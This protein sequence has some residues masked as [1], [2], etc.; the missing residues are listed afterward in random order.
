MSQ[1][2]RYKTKTDTIYDKG[3]AKE[4]GAV[5]VFYFPEYKFI[6]YVMT[7]EYKG[8]EWFTRAGVS[9]YLVDQ[10]EYNIAQWLIKKR[11]EGLNRLLNDKDKTPPGFFN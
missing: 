9:K 8:K 3:L 4:I 1:T 10:G 5:K 11:D 6:I 2:P 7:F